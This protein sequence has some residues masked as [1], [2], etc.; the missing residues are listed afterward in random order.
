[1]PLLRRKT[2]ILPY[3]TETGNTVEAHERLIHAHKSEAWRQEHLPRIHEL[4]VYL[5]KL[6]KSCIEATP[7][8]LRNFVD[9]VHNRTH[10]GAIARGYAVSLIDFYL[11]LLQEGLILKNPVVTLYPIFS[12]PLPAS[13]PAASTPVEATPWMRS[14]EKKTFQFRMGW[15]LFVLVVVSLLLMTMQAEIITDKPSYQINNKNSSES[16]RRDY[17]VSQKIDSTL[18]K[19]VL[20]SICQDETS[21]RNPLAATWDNLIASQVLFRQHCQDCHGVSGKGSAPRGEEA[22]QPPSR[23]KFAGK[24][25]LQKDVYLFWTIFEGG[26]IFDSAMPAY[27]EILQPEDVWKLVLY[28]NH[29]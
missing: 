19:T 8:D 16:P 13:R 24:G 3:R 14:I 11:L 17:F 28:I 23:L 25:L 4:A 29:L 12:E 7:T 26:R 6:G 21:I 1:M 22:G 2:D 15:L 18:C 27:K 10:S 20:K 5:L 9:W